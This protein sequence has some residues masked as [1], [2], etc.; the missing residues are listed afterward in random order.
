MSVRLAC[1]EKLISPTGVPFDI[2]CPDRKGYTNVR[3]P[4][5]PGTMDE[6]QNIHKNKK[7][8]QKYYRSVVRFSL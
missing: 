8:D 6:T 1:D 5:H 2:Y 7:V 4:G 3:D